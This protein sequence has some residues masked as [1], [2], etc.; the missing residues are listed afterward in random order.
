MMDS[1]GVEAVL[2]AP[3]GGDADALLIREYLA[4]GEAGVFAELVAGHLAWLKRMLAA[5][6][7]GHRQDM[8]DALQEILLGISLDLKKF[9]FHSSFKTFFY[10]YARNKAIDF[11]RAEK[12]RRRHLDERPNPEDVPGSAQPEDL[13]L[14][15]EKSGHIL[16]ALG[17][18]PPRDRLL[19]LMKD[20]EEL[21]IAE[22]HGIT[23]LKAG[24]IKSRL[25]RVREKL[26]LMLS[27]GGTTCGTE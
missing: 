19:L 9:R 8:E 10:R 16:E 18:L 27:Q 17:K 13:Y 21:S 22:I 26:F 1:H 24:T 4:T 2:P 11:L 5:L 6:L 25:H 3:I 7:G 15:R 23:G 14:A 12:R 20:V